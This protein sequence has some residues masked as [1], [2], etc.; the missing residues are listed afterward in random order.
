MSNMG[1]VILGKEIM[2]KGDEE[3]ILV[4]TN[5]IYEKMALA[6]RSIPDEDKRKRVLQ[7]QKKALAKVKTEKEMFVS[8]TVGDAKISLG[9]KLEKMPYNTFRSIPMRFETTKLMPIVYTE[10]AE[11]SVQV[12]GV[13]LTEEL[14]STGTVTLQLLK[15][16]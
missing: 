8:M 1:K 5:R 9:S 13:S 10:C 15:K 14:E 4:N 12:S 16:Q 11:S 7:T 2:Q 3:K 6:T